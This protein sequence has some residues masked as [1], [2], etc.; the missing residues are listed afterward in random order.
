MKIRTDFVTNSSSSSFILVIDMELANNESVRFEANGGTDET[1]RIDYFRYDAIVKVSPKQLSQAESVD[2]LI[3]MLEDGV[4]DGQV[5]NYDEKYE[6]KIFDRSRVEVNDWDEEFDAYDFVEEIRSK[7]T[8]VSQIKK[9]TISGEAIR[10][11]IASWN[12]KIS[13]NS[14][15]KV[16]SCSLMW[17][18]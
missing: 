2:E 16:C 18:P 1:G 3:Q 11:D 6:Q 5:K 12:P 14:G 13:L 8:D 4:V 15:R 7:I 17:L 10:N 9:I